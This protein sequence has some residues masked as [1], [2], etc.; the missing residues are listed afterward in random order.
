MARARRMNRSARTGDVEIGGG[1]QVEER[2]S[3]RVQGEVRVQAAGIG[4]HPEPGG[5]ERVRLRS[6]AG[7][8]RPNAVR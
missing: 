8:R 3:Y 6:G 2:G 1:P 4:H 7:A 5:P